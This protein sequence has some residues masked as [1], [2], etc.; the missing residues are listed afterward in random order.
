MWI[1]GFPDLLTDVLLSK[2]SDP[3][4]TDHILLF[5]L[6]QLRFV[7]CMLNFCVMMSCSCVQLDRR[8][9][10]I[11]CVPSWL[12]EGRFEGFTRI[13]SEYQRERFVFVYVY[14]SA[15]TRTHTHTHTHVFST[16]VLMSA[17]IDTRDLTIQLWS[18]SARG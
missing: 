5:M 3:Q 10:F 4:F 15:Y 13:V 2:C 14:L 6:S 18:Y 8:D 9:S 11:C 1:R 7:H 16:V 17:Y 12:A